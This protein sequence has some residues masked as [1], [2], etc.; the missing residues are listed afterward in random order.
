MWHQW[1][2]KHDAV[3]ISMWFNIHDIV[4]KSWL[5]TSGVTEP[6]ARYGRYQGRSE[7]FA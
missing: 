1:M 6:D 3:K 7:M 4:R 5:L 2:P